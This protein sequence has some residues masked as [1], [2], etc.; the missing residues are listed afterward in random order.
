MDKE[1]PEE[2]EEEEPKVDDPEAPEAE[3]NVVG[4]A[5]SQDVD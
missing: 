5:E 1:A 4:L 2:G 3:P